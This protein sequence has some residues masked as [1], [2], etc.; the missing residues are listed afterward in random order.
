MGLRLGGR[1]GRGSAPPK[2]K[3]LTDL[4]GAQVI[5]VGFCVAKAYLAEINGATATTLATFDGA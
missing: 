5:L 3:T 4:G 2:P 1:G